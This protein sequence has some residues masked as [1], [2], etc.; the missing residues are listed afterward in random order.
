MK[1]NAVEKLRTMG[2]RETISNRL[3]E[4]IDEIDI[5]RLTTAAEELTA[6]AEALDSLRDAIESWSESTGE[7]RRDARDECVGQLDDAVAALDS[8]SD[9]TLALIEAPL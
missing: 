3:G 6:V 1:K 2:E 8:C 4:L 7:E 9:E 5:E